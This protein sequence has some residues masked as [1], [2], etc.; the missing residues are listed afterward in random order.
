MY[1][2]LNAAPASSLAE[3]RRGAVV[4][5]FCRTCKSIYP[6]LRQRHVGKPSYGKD[7]VSAPCAYEGHAF[8]PGADWWEPAV[9]VL[10]PPAAPQPAA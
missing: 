8:D 2:P 4:G 3:E 1:R 7:H 9:V 5:K 6:A 10:D